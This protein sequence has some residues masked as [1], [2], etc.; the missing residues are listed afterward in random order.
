MY[1]SILVE[2]MRSSKFWDVV[3]AMFGLPIG[4]GPIPG[5]PNPPPAPPPRG[6]PVMGG[7]GGLIVTGGVSIVGVGVAGVVL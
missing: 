5:P 1:I 2:L 6:F 4:S 7:L 3:G